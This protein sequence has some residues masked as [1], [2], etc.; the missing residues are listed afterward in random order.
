MRLGL[1]DDRPAAERAGGTIGQDNPESTR[2]TGR[3]P[4]PS[5][6]TSLWH[7]GVPLRSTQALRVRSMNKRSLPVAATETLMAPT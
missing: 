4:R 1:P 3:W 7:S 6:S 5:Q 2:R